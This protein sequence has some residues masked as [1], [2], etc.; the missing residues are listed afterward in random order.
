[1]HRMYDSP[2]FIKPIDEVLDVIQEPYL[3]FSYAITLSCLLEN[4]TVESISNPLFHQ[5]FRCRKGGPA[6]TS[7]CQRGFT[8]P[9]S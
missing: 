6:N 9:C 3:A 8:F 7:R 5:L 4:R 1:M 2:F